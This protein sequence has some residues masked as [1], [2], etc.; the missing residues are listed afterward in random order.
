MILLILITYFLFRFVV[1]ESCLDFI[2]NDSCFKN[3]NFQNPLGINN[4]IG[5]GNEFCCPIDR[6]SPNNDNTIRDLKCAKIAFC[7]IL[8][9]DMSKG[10]SVIAISDLEPG[11]ITSGVDIREIDFPGALWLAWLGELIK[12]IIDIVLFLIDLFDRIGAFF[13]SFGDIYNDPTECFE[14]ISFGFTTIISNIGEIFGCI[15]NIIDLSPVEAAANDLANINVPQFDYE[16]R[17]R[18]VN[19][20]EYV[21]YI[22]PTFNMEACQFKSSNVTKEQEEYQKV[23]NIMLKMEHDILTNENVDPSQMYNTY[24][25]EQTFEDY[26]SKNNITLNENESA[27]DKYYQMKHSACEKHAQTRYLNDTSQRMHMFSSTLFDDCQC[28]T[29]KLN[30]EEYIL[31][32]PNVSFDLFK[33]CQCKFNVIDENGEIV[34]KQID[35][36]DTLATLLMKYLREE[37]LKNEYVPSEGVCVDIFT[38]KRYLKN[39]FKLKGTEYIEY[40]WCAV[41][42]KAGLALNRYDSSKYPKDAF[43]RDLT[44]L[45]GTIGN[46]II[47]FIEKGP[48]QFYKDF[49]SSNN[50]DTT[51]IVQ[52]RI[53]KRSVVKPSVDYNNDQSY[54]AMFAETLFTR[55]KNSVLRASFNSNVDIEKETIDFFNKFSNKN[56]KRSITTDKPSTYMLEYNYDN[57]HEHYYFQNF[58]L[59]NATKFKHWSRKA[60]KNIKSTIGTLRQN[61]KNIVSN[62]YADSIIEFSK[63]QSDIK[64]QKRSLAQTKFVTLSSKDSTILYQTTDSIG[65]IYKGHLTHDEND[66]Y[67]SDFIDHMKA[68]NELLPHIDNIYFHHYSKKYT[69]VGFNGNHTNYINKL[70]DYQTKKRSNV[71]WDIAKN[72]YDNLDIRK[73]QLYELKSKSVYEIITEA[74]DYY[75]KITEQKPVDL[76]AK[77]RFENVTINHVDN[78]MKKY[79]KRNVYE[80]NSTFHERQANKTVEENASY[81]KELLDHIKFEYENKNMEKHMSVLSKRWD[82]IVSYFNLHKTQ[83]YKT[84]EAAKH[85]VKNENIN[86]LKQ[87]ISGE[88]EYIRGLGFVN[89]SMVPAIKTLRKRQ[90]KM[91]YD[92]EIGPEKRY[93]IIDYFRGNLDLRK[94]KYFVF[95]SERLGNWAHKRRANRNHGNHAKFLAEYYEQNPS[96]RKRT[97]TVENINNIIHEHMKQR[98]RSSDHINAHYNYAININKQQKALKNLI[99]KSNLTISEDLQIEYDVLIYCKHLVSYKNIEPKDLFNYNR[100]TNMNLTLEKCHHAIDS[101]DVL[102]STTHGSLNVSIDEEFYFNHPKIEIEEFERMHQEKGHEHLH[103]II[104]NKT[105]H[106]LKKREG[107]H[108]L[109]KRNIESMYQHYQLH[110]PNKKL[111]KRSL[112]I[113][114]NAAGI[115]LSILN[116]IFVGGTRILFEIINCLIRVFTPFTFQ[117]TTPTSIENSIELLQDSI[118]LKIDSLNDLADNPGD[119]LQD[120]IDG[121]S[122]S[123]IC[124]I[125]IDIDGTRPYKLVCLLSLLLP[126]TILGGIIEPP[127]FTFLPKDL[128][129]PSCIETRTKN[130]RICDEGVE[131]EIIVNN[132]RLNACTRNNTIIDA[133]GTIVD[134][135]NCLKCDDPLDD[136]DDEL[137][138]KCNDSLPFYN[139]EV[140]L[141]TLFRPIQGLIQGNDTFISFDPNLNCDI[142]FDDNSQPI[143]RPFC[144]VIDYT[145]GMY[146][147]CKDDYGWDTW[148]DAWL[149]WLA[150]TPSNINKAFHSSNPLPLF[151][152]VVPLPFTFY[153]PDI[154]V[155]SYA[156]N[157]VLTV[158]ENLRLV[159]LFGDLV[160]IVP[161]LGAFVKWLINL[162]VII[163]FF[164]H[165]LF[166]LIPW[167]LSLC[168]E[169]PMIPENKL[170]QFACDLFLSLAK[171]NFICFIGADEFFMNLG[172]RSSEYKIMDCPDQ[173]CYVW[174][175]GLWITGFFLIVAF[176]II[177]RLILLFLWEFT[178]VFF[179]QLYPIYVNARNRLQLVDSFNRGLR[180]ETLARENL[181]KNRRSEQQTIRINRLL[182]RLLDRNQSVLNG[183]TTD[184]TSFVG[185]EFDNDYENNDKNQSQKKI[186]ILNSNDEHTFI[187]D[188]E[189]VLPSNEDLDRLREEHEQMIIKGHPIF[190]RY[191]KDGWIKYI[192]KSPKRIA[193]QFGYDWSKKKKNK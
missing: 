176:F 19:Y 9:A 10:S 80:T 192:L 142:L 120:Q 59:A 53:Q 40:L 57:M 46:L 102:V 134:L 180:T 137:Q 22:L 90:F 183:D 73:K 189:G 153:F 147:S 58:V 166:L 162:P 150:V 31:F 86:S 55:F 161:V 27:I 106:V 131:G 93:K 138:T 104:R 37:L 38:D 146:Q 186:K 163:F 92:E 108:M 125:P 141:F 44:T 98:N 42:I 119:W 107:K 21:P 158:V 1:F 83:V 12:G 30:F 160:N 136:D 29:D 154:F 115:A 49:L 96:A 60:N 157:F 8:G 100:T 15:S 56:E 5:N 170:I 101:I 151:L 133:N 128:P 61:L 13:V 109:V 175:F 123:L 185:E 94:K 95:G 152:L 193:K 91:D 54:F 191:K 63:K 79:R 81:L 26:F 20:V 149:Y 179:N 66:M 103:E 7:C 52:S 144:P 51:H 87:W 140:K 85:G 16:T 167:F 45:I 68:H 48:A 11:A 148:E 188:D 78:Y 174:T 127:P 6:Q 47:D 71:K 121:L 124:E 24:E 69:Q 35:L 165:W 39:D 14:A 76:N 111:Q 3:G 169:F 72:A 130:I 88:K 159:Q 122:D 97:E 77:I 181:I 110:E 182:N 155:F 28:G 33:D 132:D 84:F 184:N 173:F 4:N 178:K 41:G 99:K 168:F 32:N 70:K 105:L 129:W 118:D 135:G 164:R 112:E 50:F 43:I 62:K 23:V 113:L 177:L 172:E 34:E 171:S 82:F 74:Y 17:K 143:E 25:F 75:K 89:A 116:F 139:R 64:H 2:A 67:V 187:D 117:L 18:S 190:K 36:K 114:T 126:E 145:P 156:L 65:K